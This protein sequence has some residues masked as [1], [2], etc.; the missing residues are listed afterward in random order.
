MFARG[1]SRTGDFCNVLAVDRY[2]FAYSKIVFVRTPPYDLRLGVQYMGR[3]S[4][5]GVCTVA[6]ECLRLAHTLKIHILR[7]EVSDHSYRVCARARAGT[8]TTRPVGT[9]VMSVH[10]RGPPLS[11]TVLGSPHG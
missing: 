9:Q 8:G 5:P 6:S 11:R 3:V 2:A 1:R 10:S 7:S 4:G